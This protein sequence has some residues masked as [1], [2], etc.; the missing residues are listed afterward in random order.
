MAARPAPASPDPKVRPGYGAWAPKTFGRLAV[1]P[2]QPAA[3]PAAAASS[4]D[5]TADDKDKAVADK[6][7]AVKQAR[8]AAS[9]AAFVKPAKRRG[10][11]TAK[12]ADPG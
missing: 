11:K 12:D 8:A 1:E 4:E 6:A 2:S 7:V 10:G 9:K 5:A 3:R